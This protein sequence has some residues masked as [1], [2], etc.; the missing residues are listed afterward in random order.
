M[1]YTYSTVEYA[2]RMFVYRYCNGG[3]VAVQEYSRKYQTEDVPTLDEHFILFF[4]TFVTKGLS[5]V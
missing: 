4:K 3:N 1:P 5:L 2:D